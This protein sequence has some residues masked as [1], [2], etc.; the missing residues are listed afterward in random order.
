MDGA[1]EWVLQGSWADPSRIRN[2]I[3]YSLAQDLGLPCAVEFRY[4]D[5]FFNGEYAGNYM[6]VESIDEEVS[7]L[8]LKRKNGILIAQDGSAVEDSIHT[9]VYG[10]NFQIR[11]PNNISGEDVEELRTRLNS[12]EYMISE[13]DSEEEYIELKTKVDVNSLAIMY[14]LDGFTNEGDSNV[15]STYYYFDGDGVLFAGPMWDCDMSLGKEPD[16]R[17]SSDAMNAYWNGYPEILFDNCELFREEVRAILSDKYECIENMVHNE[18][19]LSMQLQNS[20]IMDRY[21]YSEL[22]ERSWGEMG[23]YEATME[24]LKSKIISRNLLFTDVVYNT[25]DYW[26]VRL[27]FEYGRTIFVKKGMTFPEEARRGLMNEYG[28]SEL[29]LDDGVALDSNYIIDRDMVI[30][31]R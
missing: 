9:E 13:C 7:R 4:V 22:I 27:K 26:K 20:I 8:D 10:I 6:I 12:I 16:V 24:Y 30:T 23:S 2:G 3:C 1:K 11:Y 15:A 17:H 29:V 14:L 31:G 18:T 28:W 25:N 21:L 19:L 5:A